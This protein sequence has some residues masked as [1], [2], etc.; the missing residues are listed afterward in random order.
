MTSWL[1]GGYLQ[2]S[3][4]TP[5]LMSLAVIKV[6]IRKRHLLRMMFLLIFLHCRYMKNWR[7][8]MLIAYAISYLVSVFV[9][10]GMKWS[11]RRKT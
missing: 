4:S 7:L 2:E 10:D 5:Q 11:I 6:Y 1:T 8:K 3:I 9:G